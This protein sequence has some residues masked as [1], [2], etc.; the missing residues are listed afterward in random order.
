MG[1]ETT[2]RDSGS[3]RPLFPITG[4]ERPPLWGVVSG[5]TRGRGRL[6]PKP[7]R[8]PSP[9][10]SFPS[11]PPPRRLREDT[12][13]TRSVQDFPGHTDLPSPTRPPTLPTSTSTG[14]VVTPGR[15]RR[16]DL[17]SPP[18][19]GC[20]FVPGV[21]HSLGESCAPPVPR[22]VNPHAQ[23]VDRATKSRLSGALSMD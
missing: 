1:F 2:P 10:P 4:L 12:P 17:R 14:F 9:S 3:T 11:A 23:D 18:R 19:P 15:L 13:G 6:F 5:G 8:P 21:L 22:G 7:H 16:G 20:H